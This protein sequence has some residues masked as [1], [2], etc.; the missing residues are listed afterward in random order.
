MQHHFI[1]DSDVVHILANR[2]DDSGSIGSG[3]MKVM[4]LTAGP[5]KINDIDWISSCSP[6]AI[7]ID[8]SSHDLD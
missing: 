3:N 1:T 4:F 2:N 6:N 7:V 8:T 5:L